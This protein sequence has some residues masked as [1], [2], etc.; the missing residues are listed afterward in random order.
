MARLGLDVIRGFAGDDVVTEEMDVGNFCLAHLG[1]VAPLLALYV[2]RK[3]LLQSS[4]L[5][6]TRR[7]RQSHQLSCVLYYAVLPFIPS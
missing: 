2:V 1:N 6:A 3:V 7:R 4:S 5:E